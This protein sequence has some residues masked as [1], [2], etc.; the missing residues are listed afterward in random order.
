V[1]SVFLVALLVG[2]ILAVF[3]M[4]FGAERRALPTGA[5]AAL[6]FGLFGYLVSR[7]APVSPALA[8]GIAAVGAILAIALERLIITRWAI[9]GE[10]AHAV[11]ERYLLQGA[12]GQASRTIPVDGTG[13]IVYRLDGS[14]R[15]LPARAIDASLLPEGADLVIDRVE[16]GVAFV[17]SWARVEA[18]L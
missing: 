4:L 15:R 3:A 6:G 11:D 2:L 5:A 13:E 14:T 8:A 10:L 1:T 16:N 9:P 18:R 7:F 17:E 12:I